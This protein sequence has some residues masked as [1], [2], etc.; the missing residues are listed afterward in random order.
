MRIALI[1]DVHGNRHAL[2]AVLRDLRRRRVDAIW[3]LGD[4]VGYGAYPDEVVQI[5]RK[6]RILS[7]AGNFDL[8][9]LRADP[10]SNEFAGEVLDKWITSAW[11][12]ESLSGP[13]R[14]YL[15]S[16]PGERRLEIEG[17]RFYLTHGTPAS[18]TER[19]EPNASPKR[20]RDLAEL[21]HADVVLCGHS[22]IPSLQ[23][24]DAVWFVNPGGVGRS[25]DGDPRASYAVLDVSRDPFR[26]SHH[27]VRYDVTAAVDAVRRHGLP[28]SLGRMLV[29]ARSLDSVLQDRKGHLR[30]STP[31]H[32][33][34]LEN[35]LALARSC[36]YDVGHTHQVTRLAMDLFD[37]LRPVHRLG[38]TPRRW[39]LCASLLHDIGWPEGAKGHHKAS[40][41][42]IEASKDLSFDPRERRIVACIARYHRGALPKRRHPGYADLE[43][44]DQRAVSKLAAI[45]RVADGLDR[46]H[47][48]VVRELTSEV[49]PRQVRISCRVRGPADEER[50]LA[51][52]KGDLF[53]EVFH[54]ELTI[55]CSRR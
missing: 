31:A 52:K 17:R 39:L 18:N 19:L 32:A 49:H 6:R 36:G 30:D 38:A 45:L 44:A 34:D 29:E 54:R 22:H 27:R 41:R 8:R 55:T 14:A 25:D 21:A 35:V 47:R 12:H 53:T 33:R 51:L 11:S 4:S 42:I 15:E 16:L 24:S 9:V 13:S 46:T 10:S 1:G 20:L 43:T 3:N 48:S 2:E 50:R 40:Q 7:I 5:L 26:A 28:E 23:R 37:Q